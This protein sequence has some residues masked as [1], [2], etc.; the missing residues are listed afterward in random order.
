MILKLRCALHCLSHPGIR[1]TRH[2]ISSRFV[3]RGLANDVQ[4]YCCSCLLF[5]QHG[6]VLQQVHLRPEKIE[7]PFRRFSHV[8]VDLLGPLPS[9]YGYTY[10]LSCIDRSTR[11]PEVIPLTGISTVECVSTMFLSWISCFGV[12]SIITSAEGWL[13]SSSSYSML[14]LIEFYLV[15]QEPLSSRLDPE[16]K[17]FQ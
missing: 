12:P 4:D 2:I 15:L 7:V 17:W 3:W 6:K 16:K 9:S 11:W 13:C 14:D 10:L 1:A 5:C 8:H